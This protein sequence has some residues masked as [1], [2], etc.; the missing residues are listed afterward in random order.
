MLSLRMS[1]QERENSYRKVVRYIDNAADILRT[2]AR[3]KEKYY[4]DE[5]Y[6]RMACSTAY[7]GT[8]L[9]L[10]TYLAL[11]GK[12]VDKRKGRLSVDDYSKQLAKVNS[13]L[14]NAFNTAYNVLHLYGYYDGE[15]KADIIRSGFDSAIEIINQIKPPGLGALKLIQ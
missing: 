4:E 10:D 15:K 14:L 11:K 12:P 5:K 7:N 8:L 9:A 1:I 2:K 3:K 6:V 13:K